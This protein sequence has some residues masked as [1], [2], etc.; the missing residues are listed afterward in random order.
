LK[1]GVFAEGVTGV[2]PTVTFPSH[3]T[4]ITGVWPAQHGILANN[5]FDPQNENPGGWYWFARD[6]RVPTLFDVAN[7]AG[8]VTASENWPVTVGA[9]SVRYLLPEFWRGNDFEDHRML[10]ALVRPEGWL[11]QLESKLGAYAT[12][13][14]NTIP[15]DESRTRFAVETLARVKPGFMALHLASLDDAQH[16]KGP[17]SP[18]GNETIEALDGMIG[19]LVAAAVAAD[20]SAIVVVVSDHG[21]VRTD[22][23]V[24]L[25]VPFIEKGFVKPGAKKD[26]EAMPWMVGGGAAVMLNQPE[27]AGTRAA[28]KEML[29]ALAA[30]PEN[31][32]ARILNN[33]EIAKLGGFPEAAFFVEMKPGYVTGGGTSGALVTPVPGTG[34]H[35]YLPD[36]PEM[37]ASFFLLGRG[38]PRGKNLGIIDMRQ[39]A[40]TIASLLGVKLP[41]TPMSAID[42]RKP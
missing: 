2:A 29:E 7:E 10:E 5:P 30:K 11:A 3:T 34:T 12:G 23:R 1:E 14:T 21:F 27:K 6:I 42:V 40:P 15:A 38:L 39:I 33:T 20:P 26:W 16:E 24:N 37:R 17:F 19:K 31:G 41:P 13:H 25:M 22:N 35:G 36:L 4:L 9:S 8:L 32:I 18:H 28:V